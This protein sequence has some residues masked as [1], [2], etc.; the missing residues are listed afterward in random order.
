[1]NREFFK[2]VKGSKT[3]ST[4]CKILGVLFFLDWFALIMFA[5]NARMNNVSPVI[6]FAPVVLC[7]IFLLIG[8]VQMP[9]YKGEL[10]IGTIAVSVYA[11][12]MIKR[13]YGHNVKVKNRTTSSN[14]RS[15]AVTWYFKNEIPADFPISL[16]EVKQGI[17]VET[18][19]LEPGLNLKIYRLK[20]V[21]EMIRIYLNDTL[22]VS[23]NQ[24][25]EDDINRIVNPSASQENTAQETVT[26]TDAT[27][28]ASVSMED[29]LKKYKSL[30]DQGL[31]TQEDYDLKKKKILGI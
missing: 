7:L 13:L 11:D 3:I 16:Y 20:N 31:I 29:E 18:A 8:L 25:Y 28:T 6:L 26:I 2:L 1:M 24:V 14:G 21:P 10:R 4:V 22:I 5:Y 30:L 27:A 12:G 9:L 23:G 15:F 19:A 17:L